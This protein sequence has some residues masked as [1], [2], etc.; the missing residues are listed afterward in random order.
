M[1]LKHVLLRNSRLKGYEYGVLRAMENEIVEQTQA[2]VIEV[3][4]YGLE[5]ITKRAGHGMRW[6]MVRRV[7]PK[8]SFTIDADVIWCILMGPENYELDLFKDW[9]QK[10]RFRIV[11]LFDTLEPQ[12][13][14][15]KR[16]FSSENFNICITS[17]QEAVNELE[18]VTG[19]KWFAIEQAVPASLFNYVPPENKIIGFS[20]YGRRVE[21]FHNTLIE[22][23][24]SNG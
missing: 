9:D 1:K 10:A 16:L 23:C 4:E 8:K 21:S 15:V 2:E 11:Y 22:F 7:L 13:A 5:T 17:F 18:R 12:I 24:K 20:S 19:K 3:P 14:L 6:D